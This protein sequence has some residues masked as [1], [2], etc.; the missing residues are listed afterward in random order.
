MNYSAGLTSRLKGFN[1]TV[2][3][4]IVDINDRIVLT[5]AF[6]KGSPVV[7]QLLANYPD[8][9]SAIF[10]TNAIDTRTKGLDVVISRNAQLNNA[11]LNLSLAA[12]FNKTEVKKSQALPKQL[13]NDPTL[14]EGVLFDREQRAR[15]ERGQP[16]DKVTFSLTYNLKRF[17]V[18]GRATRFGVVSS[19]D[20]LN[21][22]LD[23]SF[24]ARVVTD[25]SVGYKIGN[26]A[27]L[28]IGANNIGN[29]YP[30]KLEK[31]GNTSLN[32]FIYSRNATQFGFNG[33]YYY[34][35][36]VFDISNLKK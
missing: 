16:R 27:T 30:E 10:L 11:T 5:G 13:A 19:A 17:T 29:V 22:A 4:Y 15:I 24:D 6:T 21:A 23:E 18:T 25:V 20:R 8:V 12:N 28:T 14:L 31:Y 34:T 32:R 3:G 2:D 35:S 26:F 7:A 36:F 1:I 9:N 33:G